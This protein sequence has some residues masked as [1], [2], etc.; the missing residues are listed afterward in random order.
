MKAIM[1]SIR[2][3]WV[4]KILNG[5]KTIE[6]RKTKPKVELP[7]KVYIYCTNSNK[8]RFTLWQ[9]KSYRYLDDRSHNLFDKVLNSKVVAEFMLN[10]VEE[11]KANEIYN[12]YVM[13]KYACLSTSELHNYTKGNRF[14]AW[15]IDDLKIYDKPKELGEFGVRKAFQSW[16]YINDEFRSI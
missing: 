13:E 1:L 5:K 16:G 7:V 12:S 3:E 11:I 8:K 9:A 4:E 10:E 2:P 15:H 14:Y 6:I